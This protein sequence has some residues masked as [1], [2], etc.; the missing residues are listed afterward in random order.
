M[1]VGLSFLQRFYV[2]PYRSLRANVIYPEHS[3]T[4]KKQ[5]ALFSFQDIGDH[6]PAE[7]E[8]TFFL[9]LNS[10]WIRGEI[11]QNDE[12]ITDTLAA[13]EERIGV[14]RLEAA[15]CELPFNREF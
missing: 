11:R 13:F 8:G 3:T 9:F 6:D 5:D 7:D 1:L 2:T 14:L 10:M 4:W 12:N 15:L